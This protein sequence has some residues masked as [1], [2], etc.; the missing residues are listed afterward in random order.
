MNKLSDITERKQVLQDQA[1]LYKK[2]IRQNVNDLYGNAESKGKKIIIIGGALIVVYGILD[3]ALRFRP[4]GI[5]QTEDATNLENPPVSTHIR[6]ESVIIRSIK[7]QI[8]S[9]ILALAKQALNE[10]LEKLKNRQTETKE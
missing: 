7:E 5:S 1:K 4:K 8:A 10:V 2:R 3:L 9:F 6:N